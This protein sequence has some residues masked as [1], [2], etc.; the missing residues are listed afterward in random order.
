MVNKVKTLFDTV[1]HKNFLSLFHNEQVGYQRVVEILDFKK[2]DV[3]KAAQIPVSSVRYDS[4][5]PKE[6][7]EQIRDWAIAL[8]LVAQHFNDDAHKTV[9]WFQTP[10]H[11]LGNVSPRDMIRFGRFKK[12]FKFIQNAVSKNKKMN[13]SLIK[14]AFKGGSFEVVRARRLFS[15]KA[16]KQGNVVSFELDDMPDIESYGSNSIAFDPDYN[17]TFKYLKFRRDEKGTYLD[18]Q[19]A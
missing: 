8:Q 5:M 12:L 7:E 9:L 17:I 13:L 15:G 2:E 10:N 19:V 14:D 6:L 3:A 11:L 18:V 16:L 4:K 1:P